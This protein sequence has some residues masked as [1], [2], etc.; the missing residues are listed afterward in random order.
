[1]T[2]ERID[3]LIGRYGSPTDPN[4]SKA[5]MTYINPAEAKHPLPAGIGASKRI[6]QKEP[7]HEM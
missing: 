7:N 3:D 1:M 6:P 4:Y 2:K 5:Y